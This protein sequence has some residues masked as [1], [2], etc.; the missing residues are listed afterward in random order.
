MELNSMKFSHQNVRLRQQW[1]DEDVV[2]FKGPNEGW[3][4]QALSTQP[5]HR[6]VVASSQLGTFPM[7]KHPPFSFPKQR[8]DSSRARKQELQGK[9]IAYRD[10]TSMG[11][12]VVGQEQSWVQTSSL[13]WVAVVTPLSLCLFLFIFNL[14]GLIQAYLLTRSLMRLYF[15]LEKCFLDHSSDNS[16]GLSSSLYPNYFW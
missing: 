2:F 6:A 3:E 10:E 8:R 7:G 1:C 9:K 11:L 14:E 12:L 4:R 13:S 5:S 16:S 15:G